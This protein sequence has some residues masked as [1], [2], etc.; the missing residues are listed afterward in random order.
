VERND[1]CG[2]TGLTAITFST[3][4]EDSYVEGLGHH[5]GTSQVTLAADNTITF[6]FVQS[7]STDYNAYTPPS[8]TF[9]KSACNSNEVVVG[10]NL[11][12]GGWLDNIQPICAPLV[13][14]YIP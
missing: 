10:F 11:R 12:D 6:N 7:G 4:L 3:G 8:G 5:C 14:A 9:F 1:D 2:I 13:V